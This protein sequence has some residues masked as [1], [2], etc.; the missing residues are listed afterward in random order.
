MTPL[1][2]QMGE[3]LNGYEWESEMG[4]VFGTRFHAG[5]GLSSHLL[6]SFTNT[7]KKVS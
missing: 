6:V 3:M 5:V 4:A 7:I 1:Q 2:L